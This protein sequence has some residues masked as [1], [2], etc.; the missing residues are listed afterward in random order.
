V[1]VLFL[2]ATVLL[3]N[4]LLFT[5]RREPTVSDQSNDKHW[6]RAIKVHF[7]KEDQKRQLQ[8][9]K[10]QLKPN[11]QP[12][13]ARRKDWTPDSDTD[14]DEVDD[15]ELSERVMPRGERERR[16]RLLAV[17]MTQA[18]TETKPDLA[19][20]SSA[21][22][23]RFDQQGTVVE[24]SS[25]L[26][27]VDLNGR[28]VICGLRGSLSTEDTG[29]TNVVAVGDE[30]IVQANGAEHGV[31][32]EI[33]PR[34]SVLARPDVFYSHLQQ[35]IVANADQLLIVASWRNPPFW[36]ELIDRYLIAAGRNKLRPLICVNKVDLAE[37][38]EGL[39]DCRATLEPYR[40]LGYQVIF[41]SAPTGQGIDRLSEIL[42]GRITVLAGLSGVGKSSLLTA[43][44]PDLHL[45][46]GA[47]SESSG[48]G[49]HT[50]TQ[51]T[52][53]PL[54]MGGF[55]VDTPGIREFGLSGL[56]QKELIQFYPELAALASGCRFAD[57]SH[58][59][60]PDCAV[61]A[62]VAAGS[63]PAIRYET[64]Q[65]IYETLA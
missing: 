13:P 4:I 35:V 46:V 28:R 39:A 7:E 48:D 44:Q 1:A 29:F 50:T 5:L 34:R 12:K 60:E 37:T 9:V 22:P 8:K 43:V 41:A 25:G 40:T 26:C 10:K 16:R 62:A 63:L 3:N 15:V 18:E 32:E 19:K 49:R 61:K 42:R 54:A 55:V 45:R 30:V 59:H 58:R 23:E 2:S 6:Q 27:R 31:I 14:F 24:V 53:A 21:L 20:S 17:A 52:M 65:K 64:Y 47:V 56:S 33:L 38:E 11:R 36:P 51:V 57:C